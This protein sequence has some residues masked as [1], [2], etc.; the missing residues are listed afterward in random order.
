VKKINWQYTFG[1]ILIVIIGITIAFSMNTCAE[2]S[3]NKRLKTKYF[4]NLRDDIQSDKANLED[5][6][7]KLKSKRGIL[8][9]SF[10]YFP[11]MAPK[12]DSALASSLFNTAQIVEFS[13]K[14]STYQTLINS[15]DLN[16]IDNFDLRTGI[17]E[18]YRKYGQLQQDYDR[19]V[20]ISKKYIADYFIYNV[21][22]DKYRMGQKSY[23]DDIIL[24]DLVL[25]WDR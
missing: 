12:R 8:L 2:N 13:S 24:S 1:E 20:N 23:T 11:P 19:M 6:L 7:V 21:D 17:Q 25:T 22:M 18:H 14:N 16:L 10:R 15:G 5:N 4:E 9:N 3:K